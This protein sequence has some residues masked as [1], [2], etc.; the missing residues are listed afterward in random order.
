[1]Q[2]PAR[3]PIIQYSSDAVKYFLR[4]AAGMGKLT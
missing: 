4:V 2:V 1:M 3:A